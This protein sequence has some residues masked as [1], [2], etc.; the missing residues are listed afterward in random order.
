[1]RPIAHVRL[2]CLGALVWLVF[3]IGGL[4]NYYQ[5]YSFAT[6]FLFSVALVPTIALIAWKVIGSTRVERR[7]QLGFWLSFYF[8]GP[9]LLLDYLYCGLYLSHGWHFL[10][11]YWYLTAFYVL[12][13]LI[14]V[15]I[16]WV[17]AR[18]R[19]T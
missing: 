16:A 9:L 17:L 5:Q 1:M 8:T 11:D 12:P 10:V 19:P 6:M 18:A 14:L 2:A 3:W 15:P 4:P 13:W 7:K